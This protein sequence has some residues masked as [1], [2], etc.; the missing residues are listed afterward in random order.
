MS[1]D[2]FVQDFPA[3]AQTLEDIPDDFHPGPIGHRSAII[4]KIKEAVPSADFSDP[5]WGRIHGIDYSIEIVLGDEELLNGFMLCARGSDG[6]VEIIS[7]ILRHLGL[8]A[9][10]GDEFYDPATAVEHM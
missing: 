10:D 5:P 8:R 4:Q 6:A 2:V 7:T 1:W 9:T 3:N